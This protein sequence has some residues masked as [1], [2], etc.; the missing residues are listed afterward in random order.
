[1][2]MC[3]APQAQNA[4]ATADNDAAAQP[5]TA[6]IPAEPGGT[7]VTSGV[8]NSAAGTSGIG[9]VAMSG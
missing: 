6:S 1:M 9:Q 5:V 7:T 4:L 3:V 2:L 8:C